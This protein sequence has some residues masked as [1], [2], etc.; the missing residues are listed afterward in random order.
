MA[1]FLTPLVV[2]IPAFYAGE[3]GLGLSTVGL[4]F[5]LTKLWDIVTDPIAGSLTD[6]YGPANG[7]RR[8]WLFVSLPI[9]MLGT[10]QIFLP[11]PDIGWLHFAF[12]MVFLYVGWTLL[13]I[14]HISW[15]V[16]LSDDYNERSRIAAYRQAVALIGAAIVV[17]LPVLSDQF[18][19]GTES[20]RIAS[21]G[22]FVI[23]SLPLLLIIV[24][25][26]TPSTQA[27]TLT[28]AHSW[29]DTLTILRH[30]PSLRALLLGNMGILL[31]MAAT[32]SALLFYVDKV[33]VLDEWATFA[34]VPFLFSGLL[35]L[36]LLKKLTFKFGK[37]KTFRIVLI[38]QILVQP[39]LLIIPASN[40]MIATI[41]FL[42]MGAVNGAATFLPLAMI[43]D[44]KDV[45]T[46]SVVSRTGIY[47][48][49]LQSTSKVSAALAV[50]LMFLALPL[51]GFDPSSDVVN[52]QASLDGLRYMIVFLPMACYAIG[53]FSMRRYKLD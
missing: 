35:Y 45:K 53:L 27:K 20:G 24:T 18:G 4:I 44:L 14:S 29:H 28:E 37:L 6:K 22:I 47:V 13:T 33:L 3:M 40:I 50:G 17:A 25:S 48:A 30:N 11:P 52:N 36:P 38:F 51:T 7:R 12:W 39:L 2:F 16:E 32:G 34:V 19:P 31:G 26:F 9:M 15:G 43:A 42:A 46:K 8:F 49:L 1:A 5:G 21:M 41:A 23:I 10:Y